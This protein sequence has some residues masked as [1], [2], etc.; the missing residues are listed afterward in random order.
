MSVKYDKSLG[1]FTLLIT[2]SFPLN[3]CITLFTDED[4]SQYSSLIMGSMHK[5]SK[6]LTIKQKL[7]DQAKA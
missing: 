3:L 2:V 7:D 4:L 6:S 5:A 1:L